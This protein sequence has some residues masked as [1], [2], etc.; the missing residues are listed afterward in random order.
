MSVDPSDAAA[1]EALSFDELQDLF[2]LRSLRSWQLA[3][4]SE[5]FGTPPHSSDSQLSDDERMD[6]DETV[7]EQPA[8]AGVPAS[9]VV[10]PDGRVD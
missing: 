9:Q 3:E 7:L 2:V 6:E 10:D 8:E 1:G 5:N 4:E